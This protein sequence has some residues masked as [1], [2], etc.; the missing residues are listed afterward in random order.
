MC[1][2]LK[3][4]VALGCGLVDGLGYGM[5][6]KAAALS[7]GLK[8]TIRFVQLFHPNCQL[9]TFFE[10]CGIADTIASSFGG[11]N[12]LVSEAL[13][14]SDKSIEVLERQLLGG[15]KLQGPHTAHVV[16][17]LL[18]NK[19]LVNEFPFFSAVHH[20]CNRNMNPKDVIKAIRLSR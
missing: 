16:F 18:E 7:C 9:S 10:N 1:G 20:I 15:Q 5:N 4:V 11:R 13:I 8:E 12:R 19:Q 6:T 14:N 17:K 2:A 3:N